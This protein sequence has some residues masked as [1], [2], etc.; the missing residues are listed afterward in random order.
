M[1]N[2]LFSSIHKQTK[3]ITNATC[4]I[5]KYYLFKLKCNGDSYQKYRETQRKMGNLIGMKRNGIMLS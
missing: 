4:L 1:K 2:V 3:C 5:A